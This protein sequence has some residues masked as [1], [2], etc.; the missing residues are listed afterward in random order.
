MESPQRFF[1]SFL[2]LALSYLFVL[3]ILVYFFVSRM[4]SPRG[5]AIYVLLSAFAFAI[6]F[7][8]VFRNSSKDYWKGRE[9]SERSAD[10]AKRKQGFLAIR[11]LTRR[12]VFW[13]L[14]LWVGL[15]IERAELRQPAVWVGVSVN[16][17]ITGL[18]VQAVLRLRKSLKL[19]DSEDSIQIR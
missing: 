7:W 2:L 9:W 12:I 5:L 13:Q 3:A 6:V 14:V 19:S 11:R 16:L 10:D 17:C 1:R 8:R 4:L 15:W 18:L